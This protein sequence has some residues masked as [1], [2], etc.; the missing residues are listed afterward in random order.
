MRKLAIILG[1]VAIGA[2]AS[3]QSAACSLQAGDQAWLDRSMRAWNYA[4]RQISGIG[5][6]KKIKAVIFDKD[7]VVT[8]TTAMNG[9]PRNWSARLHHGQ[10]TLPD[11]STLRP[12]VISFTG[13]NGG[14]AFFVMSAPSVWR[15]ANVNPKDITLEDMMTAVLLHEATH[16]AHVPTYGA[17]IG[18]IAERNHLPED[19]N[20][21]SIQQRFKGDAD[22]AASV[23]RESRLLL[24]AAVARDPRRAA[25]LVRSARA[26]MTARYARWFTGKDAYLAQAEP[27]W[28]TFEGSGQWTGYKW[29]VDRRGAGLPQTAV[30]TGF[31]SDT[32]WTQ[33]EGFAAFMA[34]ERLAGTTW[35]RQAFHL[36]QQD[37]LQMLDEAAARYPGVKSA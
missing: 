17:Q 26:L 22:F 35:K 10:V 31:V 12:Q 11:G 23:D 30:W 19:F 21:D 1:L 8:S 33:R 18:T 24:E 27:I 20:D 14:D 16:V 32:H 34:L 3:A 2:P 29:L 15:A 7:C 25:D 37:V 36:G 6:V 9:G 4:T 28:L 5:H 13:S